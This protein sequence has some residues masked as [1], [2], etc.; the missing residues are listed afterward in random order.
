MGGI[1]SDIRWALRLWRRRPAFALTIVLTLALASAA[2][3]TVYALA[4]SVLWRPL[5]F[6][7]ADRLVF[8]WENTGEGSAIEPSR[9]TGSRFV[10]WQQGSST[11][12]GPM[13]L[14]GSAAFLVDKASG[15][16]LVNGVRVSTNYF[17]T[18]GSPPLLGRSFVAPDGEPGAHRVVILSHALWQEWFGGRPNAIGQDIRLSGQPYTIVGVMPPVVFP[19]WPVN[20]ATVT[21]DPD[22]R[23][24]WVPIPRTPALT[25]SAR[26]HVFGVVARLKAGKSLDDAAGELTRMASR[27][28]PD[29]HRA[30]VRPF[31]DQFVRDARA[32]L[33][34][35]LGAALAV[36]LVACTNLAALQ[37]SAIESRRSE[38]TVRAALGADRLR[39]GRQFAIE[40][41]MLAATGGWL[42]LAIA[43]AVLVRI[44]QLIPP[45]VPLLTPPGIDA[46]TIVLVAGISVCA[47]IALAA[48][49]FARTRSSALAAARGNLSLA[50]GVVFRLL[51]VSQVAIAVA[52]V[53]PAALL[54]QSLDAVRGQDAGFIIDRVLVGNLTLA[55][56]AYATPEQIRTAERRLESALTRIPGAR[57]VAFSYDHPLEANW[58]DSFTMPGS[59]GPADD[60]RGSAQLRIVSPGYFDTM[61]VAVIDGR[62]LSERDDLGSGGAVVV[63]EAFA[64]QIVEGA[65]LNRALRSSAPR[66]NWNDPRVPSEFRIVGIVEDERFKGL[67]RASEPA[68]YMSTRQFPQ[69][70]LALLIRADIDPAALAASARAT[71]RAFDPQVPVA[72]L[73]PLSSI[74]A[75]QLVTRRATTQV[76]D[77]FAACA[78]ALAGLGLY[79]LL[80]LVV[81]ARMRET[82]IRLAL[83]SSPAIEARRV[84]RECLSSTVAGLAV[85]TGLALLSGRL[86]QSL[87]VGVSPRDGATLGA[88]S[89][90]MLAVAAAAASLP[91][92]RAARVDPASVLRAEM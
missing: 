19:A 80:A 55:G 42:G 18:L 60:V 76:I 50:R 58:T 7:N 62:A 5:P 29:P 84:V 9:V 87:L 86:V 81:S 67:E 30:I 24:L 71:V 4:T 21:L 91:A 44:A 79:G 33:L 10:E 2:V 39:L 90:T 75:E 40:A 49:P 64:R 13:A 56:S 32:P 17:D 6:P 48:W 89:V 1:A 73:T 85:G 16:V 22:S 38:L 27:S 83:G 51:V 36:L 66:F 78:L 46:G 28:D 57:A 15:A 12:T 63:N 54:Q 34:A 11:S 43:R 59:F 70:Q 74:L 53:L 52:L 31:R 37:G 20:P 3:A 61:G 92:W 68:V 69:Q 14:F 45:S 72:N 26:A 47:A 35:L 25:A 41:T 8:V 23:R 65:V 77:A 82:G 88:V